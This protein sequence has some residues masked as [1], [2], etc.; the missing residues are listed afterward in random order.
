MEQDQQKQALEES[1]RPEAI[2]VTRAMHQSKVRGRKASLE[3]IANKLGEL[4]GNYDNSTVFICH[5]D[6]I[7]DAEYTASLIREKTGAKTVII[8]YVGP[9]IGLIP[10][11]LLALFRNP[12]TAL[13]A[14]ILLTLI[15]GF[16]A[17]V[18]SPKVLGDSMGLNPFWIVFALVI[19]GALFGVVGLL[20]STPVM[21][22]LMRMVE[23]SVER[24]NAL[25]E[26]VNDP[27]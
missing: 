18:L 20:L 27:M 12:A 15:Q 23:R 17:W 8:N 13:I 5:G 6:C 16:D 3:A 22:V 9:V 7:D 4:G 10:I 26:K 25:D 1:S 14:A 21:G 19:G 11:V 24:I 2:G